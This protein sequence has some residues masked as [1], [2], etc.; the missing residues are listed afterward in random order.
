MLDVVA[1]CILKIGSA[2]GGPLF[3]SSVG[4]RPSRRRCEETEDKNVLTGKKKRAAIGGQQSRA[5]MDYC[6]WGATDTSGSPF[7]VGYTVRMGV[8]VSVY[9][10][11]VSVN[12]D[13]GVGVGA[14]C[15]VRREKSMIAPF[16]QRCM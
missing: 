15:V 5:T 9:P 6:R 7:I 4:R 13:V 8:N 12:G 11:P 3:F 2:L 16:L 10:G 1:N 14:R